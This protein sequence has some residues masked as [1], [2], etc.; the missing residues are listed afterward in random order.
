MLKRSLMK[1]SLA[2]GLAMAVASA[3]T[4]PA[5]P[6]AA[7]TCDG[8]CNED[9]S[10]AIDEIILGVRM[11]LGDAPIGDCR[12]MDGDG[13]GAVTVNELVVAV[14][15]ALQRC[16]GPL[17]PTSTPTR[18]TTPVPTDTPTVTPT[19]PGD[20]VTVFDSRSAFTSAAGALLTDDYE[21]PGYAE[22]QDDAHMDAV[23]GL[24]RYK[25][26]FFADFDEVIAT[27]NGHIYAGGFTG[28]SFQLDFTAPSLGGAGVHA[29]GFDFA[30]NLPMPYVAFVSFADGTSRNFLLHASAFQFLS[31]P[32]DFFGLTSAV[33]ITRIHIGLMDAGATSNNLFAIDNL[34]VAA[35]ETATIITATPTATPATTATTMPTA[36]ASPTGT[37]SIAPRAT[38][39]ATRTPTQAPTS[40][41]TASRT[42]AATS[43]FTATRTATP[44]RTSTPSPTGTASDEA[45]L[46]AS[47]RVA[48][49]PIFRFFDLQASLGNAASVARRSRAGTGAGVPGCQQ[50]DC[51]L[52]GTQEVCCSDT[53]FSQSFD[54]CTFDDDLGR[55]VSLDGLFVLIS[56]TADVCTGAI[57]VGASFTASLNNFTHD[58]TFPDHSFSRTFQELGETFEI[59]PGGCTVS[60]PDP[61]GFGIRGDGHRVIDGELQ[62]FQGDGFGNILVDVASAVHSFDIVVGSTQAADGCAVD[63]VLNGSLTSGD[64]RVGRRFTTDFT[65]FHVVQLPQTG[66]LLLGLNGTVGTDCLGNVTL[67]TSEPLRLTSADTCFTAGRLEAHLGDGTAAVTYTESGAL[68]LDFGADGSVDQHFA[69]CTDVPTDQ[70]RTSLVALCGACTTL[71]QCQTGLGCFPC[72]RDCSGTTSRCTLPDAFAT[73][74]DGIF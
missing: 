36:T 9:H 65:D 54:N 24:T 50:L 31:P 48:T 30:N 52:F 37:R 69:T 34:S 10:V 71:N 35:P 7:Q 29:A 72:S 49:D 68:D 21:D 57:P 17:P 19:E 64:F 40:T 53:Q 27:P 12:A 46:T 41:P 14:S 61:F 13:N 5:A 47:T 56:D 20:S 59:T 1:V 60:Q 44:S 45:A 73:C 39:T 28:G 18:T 15:R 11:A 3:A 32:P 33:E 55:V 51:S 2:V 62:Q 74:E 63:A 67:S 26:T 6:A 66:A 25:T 43:T 58:V 16:G 42:P 23:K 38:Q 4:V 70:C 8:D 22:F